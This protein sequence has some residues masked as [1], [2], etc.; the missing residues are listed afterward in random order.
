MTVPPRYSC[1]GESCGCLEEMLDQYRSAASDAR[2]SL[3]SEEGTC[4]EAVGVGEGLHYCGV[5]M[6]DRNYICPREMTFEE[7]SEQFRHFDSGADYSFV[8]EEWLALHHSASLLPSF[9]KW[10]V[11]AALVD[12]AIIFM[13]INLPENHPLHYSN[14]LDTC[15]RLFFW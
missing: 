2:I 13:F 14:I 10:I 4:M 5:E 8:T 3:L 6:G 7:L 12:A 9:I 15:A 1:N 11:I